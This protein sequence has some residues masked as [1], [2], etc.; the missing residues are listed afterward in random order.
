MNANTTY[1]RVYELRKSLNIKQGDFAK[2]LGL[3]NSA[4][5]MIESGKNP[6]TDS[7]LRL[8]CLAFGVSEQ[9]L[10]NG[11][12][13]MFLQN[14]TQYEIEL[15][16]VFRQLSEAS[17]KLVLDHAKSVAE[18]GRSLRSPSST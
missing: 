5:S 10:R 17:Q 16:D 9:W 14:S 12:G 11:E 15:L 4:V 7:N 6:L 3:T 18:L 13:D 2:I 1:N 8:I